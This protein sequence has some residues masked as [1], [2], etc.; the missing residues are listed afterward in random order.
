[1]T[2]P[3]RVKSSPTRW[4]V[5]DVIQAFRQRFDGKVL[6]CTG[7]DGLMLGAHDEWGDH[8]F[9]QK[10]FGPDQLLAAVGALS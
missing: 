3:T 8:G 10:P 2:V 9:L 6:V 5:T 4:D 1:M 7:H